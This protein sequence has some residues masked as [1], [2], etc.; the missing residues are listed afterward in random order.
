[1]KE[2]KGIEKENEG[3]V[4]HVKA[5]LGKYMALPKFALL[6]AIICYTS[7]DLSIV[8]KKGYCVDGHVN[9][10]TVAYQASFISHCF[11]YERSTHRWVQLPQHLKQ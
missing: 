9:L 11:E 10:A 6:P 1:V 3:H 7:W 5:L 8:P 2:V 4:D